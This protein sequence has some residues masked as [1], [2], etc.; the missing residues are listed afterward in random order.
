MTSW[1][2]VVTNWGSSV[3]TNW[4]SSFKLAQPFLQNGQI[5]AGITN[6]GNYYKLGHNTSISD[7]FST[8]R[9]NNDFFF[10]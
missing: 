9:K 8:D 1:A 7:G 6:Q 2:D 4:G 5:F 3:I 10:R